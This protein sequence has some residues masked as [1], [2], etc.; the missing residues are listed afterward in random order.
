MKKILFLSLTLILCFSLQAKE[1]AGSLVSLEVIPHYSSIGKE[2][3]DFLITFKFR[4]TKDW[5]IYWQ[6]AG[7][8][9]IPTEIL[10]DTSNVSVSE[11]MWASPELISSSEIINY[12]YSDSVVLFIRVTPKD[13]QTEN[14]TISGKAKWLVCKEKCIGEST[15]FKTNISVG[16]LV[17][18]VIW[19]KQKIDKAY[20]QLPFTGGL[21]TANAYQNG[22][23]VTL[24]LNSL[25]KSI[26]DLSKAKVQF[27]AYE[28]G[29]FKN[30]E[31]QDV[32]K[33]NIKLK[34]DEFI[35]T[36]PKKFKGLLIGNKG[37]FGVPDLKSLEIEVNLHTNN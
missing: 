33:L 8:S 2:T 15:D 7:D 21:F 19:E 12:G 9:G 4:I 29:L 20:S 37:W 10:I 13:N 16:E 31:K 1:T 17:K 30:I 14:I 23:D 11:I 27:W 32:S 18:N 25:N 6:N 26:T 35:E 28:G 34:Q 3:K 36:L 5:H 22:K 24:S